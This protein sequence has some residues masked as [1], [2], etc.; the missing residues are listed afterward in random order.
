MF[1]MFKSSK[2]ITVNEDRNENHDKTGVYVYDSIVF[3]M[4]DEFDDKVSINAEVGTT[5]VVQANIENDNTK[6]VEPKKCHAIRPIMQHQR[7][8]DEFDDIN[9]I[10]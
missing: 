5:K 2:V 3:N 8:C 4:D 9:L 6:A 7:S 1:D 10:D